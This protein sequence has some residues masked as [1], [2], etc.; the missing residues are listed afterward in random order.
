[1]PAHPTSHY[2]DGRRWT[3]ALAGTALQTCLGTVYAWS[4]FQKP[5]MA[6]YG[7]TNEAVT[8][9]FSLAICFLGLAAAWGGLQL[10]TGRLAPRGIAVTGG[11]LFALGHFIAAAALWKGLLW[12][13][14]LGYGAVGGAGL[15]LAYV[16]PVATAA[17]WFPDKKGF[18]TGMVVMGFG[19]GALLMSKVLAPVALRVFDGNLAVAFAAMGGVFAVLAPSAGAFMRN[20]PEKENTG[21]SADKGRSGEAASASGPPPE[22][23]SG[24]WIKFGLLWLLFF[25][26]IFV[27]ISIISFQS[28]LLQDLL[29]IRN[30]DIDAAALASAGATLI[31]CGAIFNGLGR[32]LWGAVSDKIGQSLAFTLM[33]AGQIVAFLLLPR[34]ASPV[35][36]GAL[37]CYVLLCYGGGF[38]AMPSYV[39]AL[40]GQKRMALL[41]GMVLTAWSAGG[42]AGPKFMAWLRDHRPA[43]AAPVA[44]YCSAALLACGLVLTLL[45]AIRTRRGA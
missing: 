41:Y 17:K 24:G 20:P 26:N 32:F 45:P 1:M 40:F 28:P 39:L 27:G 35:L 38:G 44:F 9:V 29:R 13:L 14:L 25:C 18:V 6:Q 10:K 37:V 5:I 43:D 3:I 30:P 8:W 31:A 12:L 4:Y 19:L 21:A 42:V 36:F 11:A 2:P 15:G 34:A 33:L 23:G 22:A 16:V 7:W